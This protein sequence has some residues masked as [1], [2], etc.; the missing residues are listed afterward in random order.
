[1]L[2]KAICSHGS[3]D[4]KLLLDDLDNNDFQK[5]KFDLANRYVKYENS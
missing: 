4:P 1:M 3:L 2:S 5:I